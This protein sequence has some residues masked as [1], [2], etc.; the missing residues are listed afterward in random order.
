MD[1]QKLRSL[2]LA[3]LLRALDSSELRVFHTA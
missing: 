2:R 1:L 3:L